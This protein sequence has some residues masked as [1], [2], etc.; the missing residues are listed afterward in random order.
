MTLPPQKFREIVFQMLYSLDMGKVQ[1]DDLV[2]LI[3]QELAVAKS[4]ALAA[5]ERVEAIQS[6]QENLDTAIAGVSKS[7]AFERI[8]SVERN[9][10]RLAVYEIL[11]DQEMPPRVAISEAM[12]IARKFSTPEAGRFVNALL[13]A[14]YKQQQGESLSEQ[15]IDQAV[16]WLEESEEKNKRAAEQQNQLPQGESS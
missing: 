9:I 13:D 1:T 11:F 3:M 4:A 7:Y 2:R 6:K 8:P 5:L 15:E 12:R 10:L 16:K 14:I